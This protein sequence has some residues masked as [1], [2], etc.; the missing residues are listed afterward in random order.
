MI[1]TTMS[2]ATS[3]RKGHAYER[4]LAKE[5]RELG[6][7]KCVTSRAESKTR[8]D[9]LVDLCYSGPWNVQAKYTANQPNFSALLSAMPR[10]DGQ[11]NLVFHKKIRQ[12]ETVTMLKSD[13]YKFISN[14]IDAKK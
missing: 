8:D 4:T 12:P 10:E 1:L 9:Q 5:F 6:F 11:I 3:R 2:G 14:E 13:F 7:S